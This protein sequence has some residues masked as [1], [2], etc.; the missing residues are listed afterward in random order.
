MIPRI[1]SN[2]CNHMETTHQWM[3][4]IT[5]TQQLSLRAQ[6]QE[7]LGSWVQVDFPARQVSFHSHLPSG[8]E[9]KQVVC[10]LN[11]LR[12]AQGKQNLRATCLTGKMDFYFFFS[13]L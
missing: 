11:K 6:T 3:K 2:W 1:A 8:Q 10:Q 12:H 5:A 7:Q 13:E 9:P 4:V